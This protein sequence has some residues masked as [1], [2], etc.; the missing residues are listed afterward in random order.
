MRWPAYQN[1]ADC[2]A[3]VAPQPE[4]VGIL[5]VT[6]KMAGNRK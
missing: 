2:T 6:T 1:T 3:L 5:Y 4:V